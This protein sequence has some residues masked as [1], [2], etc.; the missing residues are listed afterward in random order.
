MPH[1]DKLMFIQLW[2]V[3]FILHMF[4]EPLHAV[5][6]FNINLGTGMSF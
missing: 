1:F 4:K 3:L 6:D 2:L 5:S